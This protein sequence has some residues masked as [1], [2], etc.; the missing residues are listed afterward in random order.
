MWDNSPTVLPIRRAANSTLRSLRRLNRRGAFRGA[1]EEV[2]YA[3][4]PGHCHTLRV[5]DYLLRATHSLGTRL[6]YVSP[7]SDHHLYRHSA[8]VV[9]YGGPVGV[10]DRH[11]GARSVADSFV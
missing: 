7:V 1:A 4:L 10:Y 2:R 3:S 5:A 6:L 8:D 11:P 9:L